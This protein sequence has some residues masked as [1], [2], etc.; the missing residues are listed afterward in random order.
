MS[1]TQ[2]AA[3]TPFQKPGAVATTATKQPTIRE[4]LE[5]QKA[6]FALAL[7]KHLT[8]DRFLRTA[9]TILNKNPKLSQCTWASLASCLM[10]CASLGLEPDGRRAHLIPYKDKCTLIIDY[11][12]LVELAMNS[13]EVS[14][15]HADVI[16]DNDEFV[17]DTGEI[18]THRIDF[19]KPRG[20]MYAAYV[21]ITMKDGTKKTEVMPKEDIDGIRKRSKSANEGPWVSD[22]NE[23]AKKTVFRRASK[24]IKLSPEV[25][26]KLEKDDAGLEPQPIVPAKPVFSME[27]PAPAPVQEPAA[28]P[29]A[30][31]PEAKVEVLPPETKVGDKTRRF[32]AI[33]QSENVDISRVIEYV[34]ILGF[35][36][37][38]SVTEAFLGAAEKNPKKFAATVRSGTGGGK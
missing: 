17:F 29:D 22:Y 16:C 12:G 28:V 10:D 1:D 9:L 27:L 32:N 13:G 14:H 18:K 6:Q 8:P 3:V 15:I 5:K 38:E 23:M 36:N 20:P 24:W 31:A 11:K 21:I 19:R 2:T 7:P 35:D 30:T 25:R 34:Q 37:L 4:L 26:E 33:A